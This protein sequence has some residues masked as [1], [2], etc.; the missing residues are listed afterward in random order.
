MERIKLMT[1]SIINWTLIAMICI[2]SY[3]VGLYM[4]LFRDVKKSKFSETKKLG[5]ISIAVTDQGELLI[6]NRVD[7][8]FDVY[9]EK[10][11]FEIF[12]V[13]GTRITNNQP[14]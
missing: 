1:K 11:G 5:Q 10:V 8:T 9:D 4:P 6:I 7:G 2:A 14:K 13:Y 12:K 3:L